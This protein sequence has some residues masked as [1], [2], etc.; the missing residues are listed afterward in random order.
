MTCAAWPLGLELLEVLLVNFDDE[1]D[2]FM[3]VLI[4]FIFELV[5]NHQWHASCHSRGRGLAFHDR[6]SPQA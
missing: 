5:D 4:L 3:L 6:L 2:N 1:D